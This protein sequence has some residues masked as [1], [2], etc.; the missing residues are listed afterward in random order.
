M[1]RLTYTSYLH[2]ISFDKLLK[3]FQSEDGL[4]TWSSPRDGWKFC[5][6]GMSSTGTSFRPM[7]HRLTYTSYLHQISFDKLLKY[8]QSEDGLLTW[9]S[10]RDGWKFCSGGM[11]ST[12]TSFRPMVI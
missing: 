7:A 8:F 3:Y 12:G 9:S 1:H 6:G 4:L 5:S 2:Q 10:P 11:S